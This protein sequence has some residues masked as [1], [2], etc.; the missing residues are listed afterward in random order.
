MAQVA[1]G[2]ASGTQGS[3]ITSDDSGTADNAATEEIVFA[4]GTGAN[5]S[6]DGGA[7]NGKHS[8]NDAYKVVSASLTVTKNSCV[9][10]DPVN[11]NSN[12]HRIPL[13]MVRYT[14]EIQN[15]GSADATNATLTDTLDG[16]LAYGQST[17]AGAPSAI[18]DIRD[19][20]CNCAT[21]AGSSTG[22]TISNSGQTVTADFGTIAAGTTE[23]AYFDTYIK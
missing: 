17:A 13:A 11:S 8:D 1:Q 18:A 3:D 2:G 21:P 16:N 7:K 5:G 19:A 23:C 10:W 22:D 15:T 14:I 12:P 9:I 20:A 4:D 6:T